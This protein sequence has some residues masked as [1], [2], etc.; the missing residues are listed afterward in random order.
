LGWGFDS[1]AEKEK[2]NV[3]LKGL[4][5]KK[6]QAEVEIKEPIKYESMLKSATAERDYIKSQIA[7]QY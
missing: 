7:K 5:T 4:Q 1:W 6:A 3:F 2:V